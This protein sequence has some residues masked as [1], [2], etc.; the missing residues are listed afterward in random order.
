MT[1]RRIHQ[2]VCDGADATQRVTTHSTRC[3]VATAR[4]RSVGGRFDYPGDATDEKLPVII[5][6]R[7]VAAWRRQLGRRLASRCYR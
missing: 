5:D 6:A 3:A 1:S 7:C 4:Q 2:R